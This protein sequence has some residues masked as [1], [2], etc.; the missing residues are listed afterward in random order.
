MT[1]WT[2]KLIK[3]GFGT[4]YGPMNGVLA[5][6]MV[7][8]HFKLDKFSLIGHSLGATFVTSFTAIHSEMVQSV[9]LLDGR[10][11]Y[12]YFICGNGWVIHAMLL[13]RSFR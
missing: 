5:I 11:L 10:K 1:S 4:S 2:S 3:L 7:V 8:H 12:M 6:R 13:I 9:I